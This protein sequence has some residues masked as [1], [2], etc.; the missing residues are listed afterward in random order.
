MF[1]VMSVA[2]SAFSRGKSSS[3]KVVQKRGLGLRRFGGNGRAAAPASDTVWHDNS[4]RVIRNP[5]R[6]AIGPTPREKR[7]FDFD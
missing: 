3:R 2:M 4:P 7:L 1:I 5:P 6:L